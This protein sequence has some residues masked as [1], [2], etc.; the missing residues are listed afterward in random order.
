MAWPSVAVVIPTYNEAGN[1]ENIIRSILEVFDS[2]KINGYVVIVDDGSPDGT[3]EIAKRLAEHDV[4]VHVINRGRKMGLG[5]AYREGFTF[6]INNLNVD[7]IGVMDA[8][9][10]HEPNLIPSLLSEIK[11]GKDV[12]IASRYIKGGRWS[13]GLYRKIVSKGANI[14]ARIATGVNARD[15]T[16]GYRVYRASTLSMTRMD[17][18]EQGYVFQVQMLY[19]LKQV[20]ASFAEVPLI[21][22]ERR[23]GQSKLSLGE[24]WRFFK[25]CLKTLAKRLVGKD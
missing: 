11:M 9:G 3:A 10:S 8:D 19:K 4:R 23:A 18:V 24:Y 16:S 21:F 13:A 2:N 5:S 6:V 14:I 20:G 7:A 15:L 17:D 22:R 25:W 1:I 12:A